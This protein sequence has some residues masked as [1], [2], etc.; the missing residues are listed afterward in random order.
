M[1][2]GRYG[3]LGV[4]RTI[5]SH[6][7]L[8][9]TPSLVRYRKSTLDESFWVFGCS[10]VSVIGLILSTTIEKKVYPSFFLYSLV[11]HYNRKLH[12]ETLLFFF[13]SRVD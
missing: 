7:S 2:N 10:G 9:V 8:V 5:E 11:S 4:T 12:N 1:T 3:S 13:F 6:P